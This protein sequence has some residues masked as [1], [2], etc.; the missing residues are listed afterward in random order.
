LLPSLP[1][2][3]LKIFG[4]AAQELAADRKT[5][6]QQ[7]ISVVASNP[8]V[9]TAPEFCDFLD[10]KLREPIS[11]EQMIE[12]LKASADKVGWLTKQGKFS[13]SRW[14]R[15]WFMLHSGYLLYFENDSSPLN[16][17][18]INVSECTVIPGVDEP[19]NPSVD[20]SL[21]HPQKREFK[22]RCEAAQEMPEWCRS[23]TAMESKVNLDD[24]ELLSVIGQGTFGK[25]I[26]AKKKGTNDLYA[27]KILKKSHV[28]ETA[29]IDHT[30]TERQVLQKVVHPYVVNLRYAFQTEDKLYMVMDYV[31]GGELY[32]H[33][34]KFKF[35]EPQRVR[36]FAAEI[37]LAL[38]YLHDMHFVYRDLKPENLLLDEQGHI[39]LTDFGL[40][41]K[42]GKTD[43]A[44]TF[45]GTPEYMAPEILQEVG[46]SFAV[47][48]WCLGVLIFEMHTGHT[49]FVSQNKKEMYINILK[50]PPVYPASFPPLARDLCNLLLHK[51]PKSRLGASSQGGR[52]IQAHAYFKGID[53]EALLRRE[54]AMKAEWI[55][56]IS[57]D[58]DGSMFD[59]KTLKMDVDA[60]R[61]GGAALGGKS[62]E[63]DG[64]T[65]VDKAALGTAEAVPLP[66][67]DEGDQDGN[68]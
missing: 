53:F 57:G 21:Y 15:R 62:D 63:F 45:C 37:L 50:N 67:V 4:E 17:G 14:K 13:L 38:S 52:D 66:M 54:I 40:S 2:K 68:P 11:V 41:K 12:V 9:Y 27:I 49:P 20:F 29:Q 23:L 22:L 48:W 3:V 28:R 33:L 18:M 61:S 43:L 34:K 24:F 1:P 19:G 56:V 8:L 35:F 47:D 39:R 60:E 58:H 26:R 10:I 32:Q 65:F 46:H 6:L 31:R 16:L 55:P 7:Y 30:L 25:V 64:F 5:E 42:M 59:P 36:L 51:D 44:K